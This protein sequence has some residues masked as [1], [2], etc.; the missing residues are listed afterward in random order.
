MI[1]IVEHK[2]SYSQEQDCCSPNPHDV[3]I[4][5]CKFEDGGSG[6]YYV[7]E[8]SRWAFDSLEE[9]NKV[10]SNFIETTKQTTL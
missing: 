5:E 4:L 9:L 7:I 10:I 6:K 2:I 8:T 3:Q 1:D